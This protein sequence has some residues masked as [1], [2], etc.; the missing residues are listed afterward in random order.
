MKRRNESNP[1]HIGYSVS[2]DRLYFTEHI[3]YPACHFRCDQYVY[4]ITG[5]SRNIDTI[6]ARAGRHFLTGAGDSHTRV[7]TYVVA[8]AAYPRAYIPA[9]SSHSHTNLRACVPTGAARGSNFHAAANLRTVNGAWITDAY[10]DT[11][12]P[13]YT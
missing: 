9:G 13:A 11:A 12:A 7:S 2:P 6:T 8:S 4:S 5:A 1:A 3:R 10:A